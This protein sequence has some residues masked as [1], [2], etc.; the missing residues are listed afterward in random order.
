MTDLL[1]EAEVV[2]AAARDCLNGQDLTGAEAHLSQVLALTA[3]ATTTGQDDSGTVQ[4]L[5]WKAQI[6]RTWVAFERDGLAPA[7]ASLEDIRQEAIEADVGEVAATCDIQAGMLLGRSG[8][9]GRALEAMGRAEEHRVELPP[10]AQMRLLLNRGALASHMMEL[11]GAAAD[12]RAAAELSAELADPG[13]AFK[14]LHNLGYV[15]YLA[16][17][18]PQALSLMAQA[19]AQDAEVDR[20]VAQLDRGRVLL[21]AGLV[22]EARLVLDHARTLAR[23]GGM[24]QQQ[25]EIDLEMVHVDLLSGT[26]TEAITVA[27]RAARGF[28]A[29]GASGWQR[30]AVLARLDAMTLAQE[31]PRARARLAKALGDAAR[32]ADDTSLER[33]SALVEAEAAVA[34]GDR[35]QAQAAF[36]IAE[37]LLGSPLLSTR[38][39]GIWVASQIHPQLAQGWLATAASD[40]SSSQK[41]AAGLDLRTAVATHGSRLASRDVA[42]AHQRGASE[43][44]DRTEVWRDLAGSILPTRAP[45][46]EQH[47]R[48]LSQLRRAQS[49]LSTAEPGSDTEAARRRLVEAERSVRSSDWSTSGVESQTAS[50]TWDT[51]A[52]QARV[53]ADEMALLSS[54]L[55][56]GQVH[57]VLLLPHEDPR[58]VE[59]GDFA[60]LRAVADTVSADLEVAASLAHTSPLRTIVLSSLRQGLASLD[61]AFCGPLR[62]AGGEGMPLVI[63]PPAEFLGLPFS[64]LPSRA[65]LATWVAR[66]ASAWARGKHTLDTLPVVEALA[67]PQVALGSGEVRAVASLWSGRALAEGAPVSI[68][69]TLDS[70]ARSDVLH[71]AAHGEHHAENPLFSTLRMSDGALFAHDLEGQ[72]LRSRH[73]VLSAC[74][75]GAV[76]ARAG[77]EAL[78]MAA[79]LLSLGATTV[80]APVGAVPDDVAAATMVAYHHQLALGHESA[81][82]LALAIAENGPLAGLFSCFGSPWQTQGIGEPVAR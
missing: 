59:L 69:A 36:A 5:S 70:F 13:M 72:S 82:A 11:T 17:N 41:Q 27:S 33:R 8:E 9:L 31:S 67:G 42:L 58:A 14:A 24:E 57:A 55:V 51:A 30:R 78:G 2:F 12:L 45:H 77:Q 3:Q 10:I 4:M 32:H 34:L 46:N 35:K 54:H 38:L 60:Q 16:G 56:D 26:Y 29:R 61:Q 79:S 22:S 62:D 50:E 76:S 52:L 49:D 25:G 39:H 15:E 28:L 1:D 63:V 74:H 68:G 53:E 81:Q 21:E 71:V 19:D 73:V 47:K 66:S 7:L 75:G 23:T 6:S 40:L 64:M 43:V 18:L 20:C 65:G 48:L 37:P 44:L 80:V